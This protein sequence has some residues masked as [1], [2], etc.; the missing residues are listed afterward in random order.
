MKL[1]KRKVRLVLGITFASLGLFLFVASL[2][3]LIMGFW[4]NA[5]PPGE[6]WK[7]MEEFGVFGILITI[8]GTAMC[9]EKK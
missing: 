2:I 1:V 5:G 4:I 3:V 8:A 6:K 9:I 7:A